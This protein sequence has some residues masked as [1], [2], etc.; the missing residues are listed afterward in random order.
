MIETAFLVPPEVFTVIWELHP[1]W[2]AQ[3]PH[4][5]IL[6]IPAEDR[7][8]SL[9]LSMPRPYAIDLGHDFG[10]QTIYKSTLG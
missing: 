1:E 5:I 2:A 8:A 9:A 6:T 7:V 3:E 10:L 4:T